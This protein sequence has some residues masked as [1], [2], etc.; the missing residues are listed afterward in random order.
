M[1]K[2]IILGWCGGMGGGNIYTRNKC[3]VAQKL[4]WNPIVIHFSE[5]P[6]FIPD[7][8]EYDKNRVLE[9]KFPPSYYTRD[10]RLQVV[11]RIM[12]IV[13]PQESDVFFVE[14]NGVRY[15]YWGELISKELCC[16]HFAFL[17][18]FYFPWDDN[19]YDFFSFKHKR[20]ELAG[21]SKT[22]LQSLFGKSYFSLTNNSEKDCLLAFCT[23]S[24]EDIPYSLDCS[25]YDIVIGNI[26]RSTKP[27]VQ[28]ASEEIV[29]F[30]NNHPDK[31]ILFIIVGGEK[32]SKEDLHIRALL[33]GNNN[34][35]YQSTGF[36]FPIPLQLLQK[37][38]IAIA[39]SGC[40]SVAQYANLKTIAFK[41]NE[42]RPYGVIGY[43]IKETPLPSQPV[44]K[45][46]L[47]EL[48][49][50]MI[51]GDYFS[52]YDY[53]PCYPSV[54]YSDSW[55][56]LERDTL[57][58]LEPTSKDYFDTTKVVPK[59][60]FRRLYIQTIGRWVPFHRVI[61]LIKTITGS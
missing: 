22:S 14:S 54:D 42:R 9:M 29:Q 40:I 60:F 36:L 59:S 8:M 45:Y 17:L 20:K 38:D 55:L 49:D 7:L 27:Y 23:N 31:K 35:D 46:S 56:T 12:R 50:E 30:G 53:T 33:K 1:K 39:T 3:I 41:D 21:I 11:N 43:D 19:Y 34:I 25:G 6:T 52:K 61:R 26:G 32:G 10:E 28:W 16:K 13:D 5:K 58:M 44:T 2:Y 37:I 47:S 51:F 18:E 48:L 24:V 4:G 57:Y 15:S